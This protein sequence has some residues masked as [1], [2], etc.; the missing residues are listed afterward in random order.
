MNIGIIMSKRVQETIKIGKEIDTMIDPEAETEITT[1]EKKN[2]DTVM[3][4]MK[5][6]I[7]QNTGM[8]LRE[9]IAKEKDHT[10]HKVRTAVT[11]QLF[12]PT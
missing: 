1:K 12:H 8:T 6:A 11:I 2:E 10:V 4:A 3:I 5:T 7:D 9:S